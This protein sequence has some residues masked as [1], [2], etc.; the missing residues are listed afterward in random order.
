MSEINLLF[1]YFKELHSEIDA[2]YPDADKQA[3]FYN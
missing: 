3:F 1:G 2:V